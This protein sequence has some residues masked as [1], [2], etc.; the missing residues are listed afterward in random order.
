MRAARRSIQAACDRPVPW[1]RTSAVTNKKGT[2]EWSP[3]ELTLAEPRS[4]RRKKTDKE[5]DPS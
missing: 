3:P 1:A 5:G 2:Q 4:R